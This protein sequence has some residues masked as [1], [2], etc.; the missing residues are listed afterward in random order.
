MDHYRQA[1]NLINAGLPHVAI[2]HALLAL[3]DVL[4]DDECDCGE[5][6]GDNVRID[7]SVMA[8]FL[9]PIKDADIKDG[10]L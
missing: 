2:A 3:V 4:R 1:E 6:C 10:L 7:P 8:E 9:R 5:E